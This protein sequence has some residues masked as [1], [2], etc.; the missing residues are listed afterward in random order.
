MVLTMFVPGF[1]QVTHLSHMPRVVHGNHP[2]RSECARIASGSMAR[3]A[4]RSAVG[5]G[6]GLV[7]ARI[8]DPRGPT[9]ALGQQI[10]G[11]G[12]RVLT[13]WDFS[14]QVEL[15]SFLSDILDLFLSC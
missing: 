4:R 7:E 3:E 13:F 12:F 11:L 1:E 8:P 15:V 6:W 9:S 2:Q 5:G 14:S 10:G